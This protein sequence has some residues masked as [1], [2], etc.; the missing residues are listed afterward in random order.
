MPSSFSKFAA[1]LPFLARRPSGW[2]MYTQKTCSVPHCNGEVHPV[3][4]FQMCK[5]KALY[6]AHTPQQVWQKPCSN[7]TF[8][9]TQNI[10]PSGLPFIPE[11]I[12]YRVQ[13]CTAPASSAGEHECEQTGVPKH[14]FND[15]MSE[16]LQSNRLKLSDGWGTFMWSFVHTGRRQKPALKV[17]FSTCKWAQPSPPL[18][19]VPKSSCLREK[20]LVTPYLLSQHDPY[21]SI[22][23][24]CPSQHLPLSQRKSFIPQMFLL[25]YYY[26]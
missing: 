20:T 23:L 19:G 16:V 1:S 14:L 13:L 10:F 26:C 18:F 15:L 21:K 9:H 3:Q 24:Q 8:P 5:G 6:S 4:F 17:L 25:T 2:H 12:W 22:P 7:V 11:I